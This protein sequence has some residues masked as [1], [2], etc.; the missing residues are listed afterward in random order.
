MLPL[1]LTMFV[2]TLILIIYL[3]ACDAVHSSQQPVAISSSSNSS[4]GG[5]C[6]PSSS[7]GIM[8]ATATT[9]SASDQGNMG[10][11]MYA[12]NSLPLRG[13]TLSTD[14]WKRVVITSLPNTWIEAIKVL[15]YE[16]VPCTRIVVLGGD[17]NEYKSTAAW[18][19]GNCGWEELT[20][21]TP[22]SFIHCLLCHAAAAAACT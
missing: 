11:N 12:S 22:L 9:R 2:A 16:Y 7:T 19:T 3:H 4:M 18:I 13:P 15:V 17:K 10:G 21:G 1:S 20:A 5:V 8:M 6:A 14:V